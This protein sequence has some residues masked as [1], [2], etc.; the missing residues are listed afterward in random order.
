M[1]TRKEEA[2]EKKRSG[3]YNCTQ[4]VLCSYCDLTGLDEE[5]S[6]N[7]ANSFGGGMGC[8]EGTCGSIVGAGMV[9]G[10]VTKDK[11]AASKGMRQIMAKFQE[12]NHA[13]R[14]KELK[15]LET[16]KVLRACPDCVAD[17]CEFLEEIIGKD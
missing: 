16:K 1:K 4:S 2:A 13:T 8:G 6:R 12:R 17:A 3:M 11:A 5:T 10:M 9:L 14:C 7:I 15:G